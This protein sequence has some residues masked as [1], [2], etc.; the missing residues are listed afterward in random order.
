MTYSR[1]CLKFKF[2]GMNSLN[3]KK[4]LWNDLMLWASIQN[5]QVELA[6]IKDL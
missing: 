4:I 3:A 1:T 2:S 5:I 6:S